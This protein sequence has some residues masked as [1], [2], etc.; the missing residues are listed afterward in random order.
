VYGNTTG[1]GSPLLEG[2]STSTVAAT[3]VDKIHVQVGAT[4]LFKPIFS[5]LPTFGLGKDINL[6]MTFRASVIMRAL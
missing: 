6:G 3:A 5:K 4:F 1:S 2:W